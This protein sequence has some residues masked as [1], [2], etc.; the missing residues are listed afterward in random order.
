L[1]CL[2]TN[3]ELAKRKSTILKHLGLTDQ[4]YSLVTIH[5]AENTGDAQRMQGIATALNEVAEPIVFPVHPRTQSALAANDIKFGSHVR[6][7]EPVGYFDMMMLESHARLIATDSGGVQ[8][9]AYY[10]AKPCLTL[11]EETEWTETVDAGWN[12]LVGADTEK[13]VS[14]WM[15]FAPPAEH[16]P[17]LGDGSAS[18][19]IVQTLDA[20][21]E[22]QEQN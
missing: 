7:I 14:A 1:D 4:E 18:Q 11:R 22:M 20:I 10:L 9:E 3:L 21:Y 2:L 12:Q 17:V 5:R 19:R 13:I 15:T 16:P 6:L 8:R